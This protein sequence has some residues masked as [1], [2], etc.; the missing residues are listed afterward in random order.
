M[1][2]SRF[3]F[4]VATLALAFVFTLGGSI[5]GA[6]ETKP[7]VT[8]ELVGMIVASINRS[9]GTVAI[10]TFASNITSFRT[11]KIDSATT[12]TVMDGPA[13]LASLKTGMV[14]HDLVERDDT[15]LDSLS[16]G[17]IATNLPGK[18]KSK[19]K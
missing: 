10:E 11:Y 5:A 14:V 9:A 6:K 7:K 12:L 19:K 8:K 18:A 4:T 1:K 15:T 2:P 13:T 16:L 3:V 17:G